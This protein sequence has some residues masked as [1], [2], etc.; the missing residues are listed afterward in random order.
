[1]FMESVYGR[2]NNGQMSIVE[3]AGDGYKFGLVGSYN[4]FEFIVFFFWL[5]SF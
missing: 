4:I 2:W 3:D 1:M 5:Q